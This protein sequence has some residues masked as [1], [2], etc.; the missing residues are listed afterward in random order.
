M[1]LALLSDSAAPAQVEELYFTAC[2]SVFIQTLFVFTCTLLLW[3]TGEERRG[4]CLIQKC[5]FLVCILHHLS[6]DA[7]INV[8]HTLSL[9]LICYLCRVFYITVTGTTEEDN[10]KYQQFGRTLAR[11]FEFKSSENFCPLQSL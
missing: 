4:S 1:H 10:Q 7:D 8:L 11:K 9:K 2:T 5:L 3:V 6:F